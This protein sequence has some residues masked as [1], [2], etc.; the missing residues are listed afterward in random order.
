MF[1]AWRDLRFA[2]GRFALIIS[3]IVLI[4]LLVGLLSGLMTGLRGQ[5]ISAVEHLTADQ[6]VFAAPPAEAKLSFTDSLLSE[7]QVAAWVEAG[8][9]TTVQPIGVSMA[10]LTAGAQQ[11]AVS[12]FG[13]AP[14]FTAAP[15]VATPQDSG[16]LVLSEE[17]AAG[18][19]VVAGDEVAIAGQPYEIAA[20]GQDLWFS[21]TPVVWM[22]LADWQQ[23]V[24]A[25]GAPDGTAATAL[26][27]SGIDEARAA[28]VNQQAGTVTT[29]VAES[30]NAIGGFSSENGSLMAMLG[31]L[32]LISGLVIGSFF[33]VWTIQRTA[34]IAILKALGA[35]S[36]ALVRDALGQAVVVLAIGVGAG[37]ALTV[38]LGRAAAQAVP[39]VINPGTTLLPGALLMALGVIGAAFALRIILKS[40]PLTAIGSTR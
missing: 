31:M 23:T 20:V 21:H 17:V 38:I 26:A 18:L 16:D 2:R 13:V 27:V 36:A 40:D 29:S 4:T 5:N 24:A 34:D 33:M 32:L 6:I 15:G 8:G 7:A 10:R 14:E 37:L 25:T 39:F 22:N 3:V 12:L 9:A 30:F 35:S 11:V 28:Q 1:V 19:G